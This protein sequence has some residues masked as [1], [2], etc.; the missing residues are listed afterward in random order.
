MAD[1]SDLLLF[2]DFLSNYWRNTWLIWLKIMHL[3]NITYAL[4]HKQEL[5]YV[6]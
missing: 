4:K 1:E 3:H 2:T 6:A 5:V